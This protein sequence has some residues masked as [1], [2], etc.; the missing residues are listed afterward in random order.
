MFERREHAAEGG[1]V[2]VYEST[3]L[4]GVG[5]AHAFS[6]RLGGISPPPFDSLNLGNPPGELRDST[7]NIGANYAQV[8]AAMG[9]GGR[10]RVWANQVHG[11]VVLRVDADFEC[12]RAGDALVAN[13][14]SCV[15]A[16]RTADCVP[17][18]LASAGGG[19]VA[20]VHAGWR[21]VIAGVVP[22]AVAALVEA[23]ELGDARAVVA[24]IGP[25]IGAEAMEVGAE[26]VAEFAGAFG[27]E[28]PVRRRADG[29][30][31]VDLRAACRMQLIRCGV[32]AERIDVSDRCTYRDAGEFFSHRRS[33]GTTGRM[34]ALIGPKKA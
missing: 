34:A 19:T 17:I 18:L 14:G 30:G 27:D 7:D 24:A 20:A 8:Q 22:A 23:G 32:A 9:C 25:C 29:K 28:A 3:L 21:G 11:G 13:A 4:A 10:R 16:V 1:R 6:T 2:V 33:G 26:V 5:A 31:H 15:L 12:G